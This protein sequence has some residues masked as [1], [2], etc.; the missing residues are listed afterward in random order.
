MWL[1]LKDPPAPAGHL[2]GFAAVSHAGKQTWCAMKSFAVTMLLVQSVGINGIAGM[3][4]PATAAI[5]SICQPSNFQS[6]IGAFIGNFCFVVGV[7]LFRRHLMRRNWRLTLFATQ[8]FMALCGCLSIMAIYDSFGIAR[9]G[10]FYMLQA[11]VPLLIAGVGQIVG[12]LAVVEVSP[13]GLEATI[14][15]L[16]ISASNGAQSLSVALQTS[17]G[18]MFEL[19][20][21]SIETW[22]A[23]P[24]LV[25]LYQQ[26]LVHAT[27]FCLGLNLLGAAVFVWFLPQGPQ[28]CREWAEKKAWHTTPVA[29]LN[30]VLLLVPLLYANITVIQDV[31]SQ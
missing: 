3:V 28:Q 22:L 10:W 8:A 1:W 13:P 15:E 29:V 6:G 16:L 30:A 25:P 23:H 11:N 31:S 7:W 2:V 4:N 9:N 14:Y 17:F 20:D 27:L 26:R 5:Q 12:S 21:I 24:R 19:T 18:R